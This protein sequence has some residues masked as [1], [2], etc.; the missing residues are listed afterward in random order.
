[1]MKNTIAPSASGNQPPSSTLCIAA[2]KKTASMTMK[3][4]V[5]ATQSHSA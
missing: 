5:A 1:M 2:A 4:D 3:N